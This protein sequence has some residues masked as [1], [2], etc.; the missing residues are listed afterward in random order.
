LRSQRDSEEIHET[1]EYLMNLVQ[2]VNDAPDLKWK[3]EPYYQSGYKVTLV[4]AYLT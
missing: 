3:V 2:Q 1:K 4:L